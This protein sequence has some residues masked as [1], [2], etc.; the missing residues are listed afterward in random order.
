MDGFRVIA[1]AGGD[2]LVLHS[3]A[4]RA[5]AP[6]FPELVKP[7]ADIMPT[8]SVLDGELCAVQSDG[9]MD[10]AALLRT[11]AWRRTNGVQLSF[12]AIDAL[13]LDGRDI[14]AQ[15]LSQRWAGLCRLLQDT[16]V[17]PVL[18]TDD[19]DTALEWAR[20][21]APAG[22][23]GVVSRRWDTPYNPRLT[24]AWVK[25]RSADST[26]APVLSVLGPAH[27]PRAVRVLLDDE[28]VT[29]SP[30]LTSVQSVQVARAVAGRLGPARMPPDGTA[31]HPVLE[32]EALVAEVLPT[33]GRHRTVRFVRLR[34]PD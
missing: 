32:E 14:R 34:L 22:V 3:R 25:W 9:R 10:F 17:R 33:I 26:D 19:R 13:A 29:T 4:G 5:L 12:V 18:S 15:P 28:K 24:R 16:P 6:E 1:A 7:L 23:E 2:Q 27:R 21:L 11:A 20:T 30:R 31:E 8:G